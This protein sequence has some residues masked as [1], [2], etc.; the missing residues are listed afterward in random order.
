MP[1]IVDHK[2]FHTLEVRPPGG[3]CA[4]SGASLRGASSVAARQVPSRPIRKSLPGSTYGTN[5]RSKRLR[6]DLCVRGVRTKAGTTMNT[7]VLTAMAAGWAPWR[8]PL[9][10]LPRL[11]SRSARRSFKPIRN[12]KLRERE[13]LYKEFIAEASRL[14][15][16]ALAHSLERPDQFVPLYGLLSCIRLVSGEA[17]VRQGEACC[18][19]IM[20]LYGRPNLTTDQILRSSRGP[21]GRRHRPTQG[22]QYRLPE[23]TFGKAVVIAHINAK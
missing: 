19:R 15:V 6:H 2:P 16:D 8:A 12:G 9:L 5:L 22:V 10:R 4:D 20:E 23:R 7:T 13:S 1:V 21:R 17:V 14:T 11:G 3:A 18:R